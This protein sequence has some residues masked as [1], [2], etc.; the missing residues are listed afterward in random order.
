MVQ[1]LSYFSLNLWIP[2]SFFIDAYSASHGIAE[3][4]F[5]AFVNLLEML[6]SYIPPLAR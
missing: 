2:V 3:V 4:Y 6:T 5:T 1:N